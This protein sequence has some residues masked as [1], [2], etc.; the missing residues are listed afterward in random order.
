MRYQSLTVAAFVLFSWGCQKDAPFEQGGSED[1]KSSFNEMTNPEKH[2]QLVGELHNGAL[3]YIRNETDVSISQRFFKNPRE[4]E[5][6]TNAVEDYMEQDPRV[7]IDPDLLEEAGSWAKEKTMNFAQPIMNGT[8]SPDMDALAK[9][10]EEN[11]EKMGVTDEF[12]DEVLYVTSLGDT[13][14][15]ELLDYMNGPFANRDWQGEDAKYAKVFQEVV[16]NSAS[17]WEDKN[18]LKCST[19][20][21]I[22][23]GIGGLAGLP[24]GG[25]GSIVAGTAMSAG[26]N[27]M[28]CEE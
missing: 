17:Y 12:L 11:Q 6:F 25:A 18:R 19:W 5:D 2:A 4:L 27:E 9:K 26:T 10:L 3:D 8:R 20:V 28:D 22:N 15:S 13:S 1:S 7:D 16:N 21:I 23:D 14:A 24:F